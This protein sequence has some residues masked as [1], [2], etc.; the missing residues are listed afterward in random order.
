MNINTPEEN[1]FMPDDFTPT[2]ELQSLLDAMCDESINDEQT[3]RL[4]EILSSDENA[5][6]FY[7]Q[8]LWMNEG[9]ARIS[10]GIPTSRI[11]TSKFETQPTTNEQPDTFGDETMIAT[12]SS[13]DIWKSKTDSK[14]EPQ[15]GVS[16]WANLKTWAISAAVIAAL[17][18][19]ALSMRF[20]MKPGSE[21]SHAK[22]VPDASDVDSGAITSKEITSKDTQRQELSDGTVVIAQAGST[23]R[24]DGPRQLTLTSG[25]LYLIVAKSKTP[26]VVKTNE[27][28]ARAMGT[29]FTVSASSK[30]NKT[31]AAVAQGTVILK[32]KTGDVKLGAGQKGTLAKDVAPTREPAKRLSHLVNWA[33]ESLKQSEL[34]VEPI[35]KENGLIAIDPYGQEARLTLRKYHVDV[36][37]EDGIARTTID[38]TFFNHNPWNTEGTFYFPLPRDAS[39]SRLAMYVNGHLNEGGMVSRERGQEIYTEILYQRRD[40]ALL[41]MMEGNMFKMRIF[42]LEG[43]QE[44]RIFLSYTQNLSELYGTSKYWFPMDH[45]NDIAKKLSIRVRIKDGARDFDPKSSTHDLKMTTIDSDLVMEYSADNLKPDQDFLLNLIAKEKEKST[46]KSNG[47]FEG[48]TADVDIAVS[49]KGDQQYIFAK[50]RPNLSGE[51]QPEPRQWIVLNDVSGSRSNIDIQTQNYIFKRLIKEA[52]DEDSVF[53]IDLNTKARKISTEPVNV[54]SP[55]AK[56]LTEHRATRLI[57]ATN[58]E[59]GLKSA[60]ETIK[61]F[62]LNNPHVVYLGDGVATDGQKGINDLTRILP[63]KAKFVGIGVGKKVDSLFLQEASNQ[64]GGLFATINP[65]E[66]IDWRVF[67]LLAALNTPRLTKIRVELLDKAGK[68]IGCI[69]YPSN[70]VIAAGE[71]LT[72]TAICDKELPAQI[73]FTGAL[74]KRPFLKTANVG[75]AKQD[76]DYLPRLWA[77]RHIDELL[78]SDM[79]S[80]EEIVSL[81]KEFYVVTPYTSL[82]VLE[83]DAMYEQYNVQRGRTDHWASYDA[84][85]KIDV[86]KEPVDWNRWGWYRRFEGEDSKVAVNA[87]PKTVQQ[88][89]DNIQVRVNAPFYFWNQT[90]KESRTG[91]YQICDPTVDVDP[92]SDRTRMLTLWFLLTAGQRQSAVDW[93]SNAIGKAS[94]ETNSTNRNSE[95]KLRSRSKKGKRMAPSYLTLTLASDFIRPRNSGFGLDPNLNSSLNRALSTR[96]SRMRNDIKKHNSQY[97]YGRSNDWNSIDVRKATGNWDWYGSDGLDDL[98]DGLTADKEERSS[99][100][101]IEPSRKPAAFSSFLMEIKQQRDLMFDEAMEPAP[102]L[103]QGRIQPGYFDASLPIQLT[104]DRLSV[105]GIERVVELS[106]SEEYDGRFGPRPSGGLSGRGGFGGG[107]LGGGGGGIGG[108][109]GGFVYRQG[110]RFDSIGRSPQFD[111]A[112]DS[113][114]FGSLFRKTRMQPGFYLAASQNSMQSQPGM[115]SVLAADHLQKRLNQ[116]NNLGVLDKKQTAE[117][118]AIEIAIANLTKV[119]ANLEASGMFWGY[120]GWNYRPPIETLTEPTVQVNRGYSWAFDLTRYAHGLYSNQS[121]IAEEVAKQ[122]GRKGGKPLGEI[123]EA[124]Q[125]LISDSR[126]N[127]KPVTVSFEGV[128]SQLA[129]GPNDQFANSSV[130]E[131]YLEEKFVCDGKSI[132]QLYDEL[133]IAARRTATDTRLATI[134]SFVPHL[135]QPASVLAQNFDV[136]LV[137][138]DKD[139]FTLKLTVAKDKSENKSEDQD[140]TKEADEEPFVEPHLLIK[141]DHQGRLLQRQMIQGEK[142]LFTLSFAYENDKVAVNWEAARPEKAASKTDDTDTNV[143]ETEN[144][145]SD[146]TESNIADAYKGKGTYQAVPISA[147]ENPFAIKL[148]SQVVFD[149]PIMKPAFYQQKLDE[150]KDKTKKADPKKDPDGVELI[151]KEDIPEAIRLRRHQILASLQDFNVVQWGYANQIATKSIVMLQKLQNRIKQVPLKGDLTL[152]GST[153][154]SV[155]GI[156]AS[157]RDSKTLSDKGNKNTLLYRY[158]HGRYRNDLKLEHL[159][160][161]EGLLGHLGLYHYC[162]THSDLKFKRDFKKRFKNSPL[163]LALFRHRYSDVAPLLELSDDPRWGSI[164]LSMAANR[165]S[166]PEDVKA[167]ANVFWKLAEENEADGKAPF[168]TNQ[169]VNHLNTTDSERT[170]KFLL[171]RLEKIKELDSLPHLLD[172]AERL[173]TWSQKELADMAFASARKRLEL[174]DDDVPMIRILAIGQALWA[175]GRAKEALV[176]YEKILAGLD[177]DNI[178]VSPSLLAATA[179]LAQQSGNAQRAIELEEK[180]LE[181]EQP[182]LPDAINLNSFRQRYNWLWSQYQSAIESISKD[183]ADRDSRIEQILTRAR[184]TWDRWADVDRDNSALPAMMASLLNTAGQDT[185][186]WEYLSTV[187]DR[188]PRDAKSYHQVGAWFQG[189]GDIAKS[190]RFFEQAPQWDTADPQWIFHYG[191]ALKSAG[192]KS[193]ANVQFKKI[194]DGKWAP[195]LQ[196][197]VNQARSEVQ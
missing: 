170:R 8:Y 17:C 73:R 6:E 181:L 47:E 176:E 40:P 45:T 166:K 126:S 160:G 88:I 186:S 68:P 167:V 142:V 53:L 67:D 64:N 18:L 71:T 130:S 14:T 2:D 77:K 180:A 93:R 59:A 165:S 106:D 163:M 49:K 137:E 194:V 128:E 161:E 3:K 103:V 135:L 99:L 85:K 162:V 39:V 72:V 177:A 95:I 101:L 196:S 143:A 31:E 63:G 20:L 30:S 92:D 105:R 148:D 51:H 197:W 175:G 111:I 9:I 97:G 7:I 195:G 86:V 78:K 35:E 76:A 82:I 173:S 125:K 10:S 41:E 11:D 44:K 112:Y 154:V 43:R 84:P 179:R 91:L 83:D 27:G 81:S 129:V 114:S 118:K 152:H 107:G 178:P 184:A 191:K 104:L 182:Y 36:Y 120:N 66:D 19:L 98:L 138:S 22:V 121:D 174:D 157:F 140:V 1:E 122:Y 153:G 149:M 75:D 189:I 144:A 42:P 171:N 52:D 58:M 15:T 124:T 139:S 50:L 62:G 187:I 74:N 156:Q 96:W 108:G 159:V 115:S 46:L 100:S 61:K 70:K 29:R 69:A 183:D 56:Q 23:Y 185:E 113:Q 158:F 146:A 192:R 168:L 4:E 136:E 109:R 131:M 150:L 33:R 32:S 119:G 80:K 190:I 12:T 16:S 155:Q 21:G 151:K 132:V 116:L 34:L 134:R 28:E 37:I 13:Q 60:R 26:F 79:S 25:E 117:K 24:V 94:P 188:K 169:I 38:Q 55:E 87:K 5:L 90:P 123:A 110:L 57:G 145:D 48:E 127:F 89:V 65:N 102:R 133:G 164:A 54:L 193:E 172:F 147:S 141:T